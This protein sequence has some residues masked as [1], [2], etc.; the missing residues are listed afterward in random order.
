MLIIEPCAANEPGRPAGGR[1]SSYHRR[2]EGLIDNAAIMKAMQDDLST[3]QRITAALIE[4][5][6]GVVES[7]RATA[8]FVYAD[9]M[10]GEELPL[11]PELREKI[12]YISRT[13]SEQQE[14]QERGTPFIRVP[15]VNMTR[16]GQ[17]KMAVFLALA[18][19]LVNRGDVIVCLTGMSASENLDTLIVTEVGRDTEFF[20][21]VG[22][23][24]RLPEGVLPQVIERLIDIAAEL[25]SE[26]REGKPVG[27]TFV[28][29]DADRVVSL[30]RQLVINPF[31]GYDE[32]ERNVLD[33]SLEET[34]KELSTIDGAF[35]I[36][37]DGVMV[38]CGAYLKTS[39]QNEQEY[40]LPQGLGARHHA[41]AGI[42]A[43]TDSIAITV[44][45]STGTVTVFRNGHIV[46]AI[47]KPRYQRRREE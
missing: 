41:A 47:D 40:S 11:P 21:A 42:T 12:F 19:G 2:G 5:I 20:S 38:T 44:S 14:Q 30:S 9:A 15:N 37:G 7:C 4:N 46:T 26:G 29:G 17:V 25:G 33:P 23:E 24:G 16:L 8:V 39:L 35:I 22:S 28:I 43:V 27:A 18:K 45:E 3:S 10:A 31:K 6:R 32:E 13:Q 1:H 34:V 36:N